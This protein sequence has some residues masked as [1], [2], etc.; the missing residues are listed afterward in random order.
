MFLL[1]LLWKMNIFLK[2]HTQFYSA[3]ELSLPAPSQ[4]GTQRSLPTTRTDW[5]TS[6]KQKASSVAQNRCL[7]VFWATFEP[8]SGLAGQWWTHQIRPEALRHQ[9]QDHQTPKQFSFRRPSCSSANHPRSHSSPNHLPGIIT[10]R[11]PLPPKK[12]PHVHK[13]THKFYG[14]MQPPTIVPTILPGMCNM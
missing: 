6:W 1:R 14:V 4:C 11:W 3:L 10:S 5:N 13:Q 8:G 12:Q 9:D 7:W 2:F